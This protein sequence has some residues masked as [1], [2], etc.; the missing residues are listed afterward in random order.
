MYYL[1]RVHH[2]M[3]GEYYHLPAGERLLVRAFFERDME[4][5]RAVPCALATK[6]RRRR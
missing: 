1:F 2:R 4:E 6:K 5:R 3:P